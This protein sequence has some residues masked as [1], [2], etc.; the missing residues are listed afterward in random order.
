M[1]VTVN[2]FGK[3]I[4]SSTRSANNCY[5]LYFANGTITLNT[6]TVS[7]SYAP[8]NI[9]AGGTGTPAALAFTGQTAINTLSPN[10]A[11]LY[12]QNH[13]VFRTING[14]EDQTTSPWY[15]NEAGTAEDIPLLAVPGGRFRVLIQVGV[16]AAA[17]S[18]QTLRLYWDENSSGT[19]VP[20]ANTCAT[21]PICFADA[22]DLPDSYDFTA[23]QLTT[24]GGTFVPGALFCLLYT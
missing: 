7:V 13:F 10:A 16:T 12:T 2:S 1:T 5:A 14:G 20:L 23:R 17:A 21:D 24:G 15:T 22:P 11:P 6:Q 19:F 9:T 18:P 8:G 4:T 3:T